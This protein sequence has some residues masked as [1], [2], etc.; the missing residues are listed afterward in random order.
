MP[1]EIPERTSTK[2]RAV[3][4][5][6]P[7][8]LLIFFATAEGQAPLE[9][10]KQTLHTLRQVRAALIACLTPLP[11]EEK[12]RGMRITMRFSWDAHG[13][14]LGQPR[15]TYTTPDVPEKVRAAYKSAML[16]SLSRCTPLPF[17]SKLGA[18]FAGQPFFLRF[19]DGGS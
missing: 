8:L 19:G 3:L 12:Y 11:V 1:V 10:P 5:L 4:T 15:F 9:I 2:W 18:S 13:Q 6:A 7:F 14:I 16:E 17:S